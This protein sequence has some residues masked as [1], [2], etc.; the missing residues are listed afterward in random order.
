[1]LFYEKR[2]N[3]FKLFQLFLRFYLVRRSYERRQ[4]L[5]YEFQPYLR[6]YSNGNCQRICH[7]YVWVSTLPEILPDTE[8]VLPPAASRR[9]NPS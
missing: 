5:D 4:D 1:M 9:F 8:T 6:F 2:D 7:E 3:D